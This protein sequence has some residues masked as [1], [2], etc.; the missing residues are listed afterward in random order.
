MKQG[1]NFING[2]W[3]DGENSL[4]TINPNNNQPFGTIVDSNF[5]EVS[6]AVDAA[7]TAFDLWKN[8]AMVERANILK[9]VVDYLVAA[10]GEPSE[11]TDL[12]QLISDEM[13]KR[14]PE[15][16]IEVIETSDML[17]YFVLNA[18]KYLTSFE[19]SLNQD[20]WATKSSQICF[21]PKGVVAII[22]AWNYPL[23]IPIWA[24][25]PALI[26]GNTVVFKPSEHSTFVAI[27]LVKMFEKAGLPKGVLNL[28]SGGKKTGEYLIDNKEISMVSFTGSSKTGTAINVKC[29]QNHIKCSLEL[30]G[31]DA[32]LVLKDADLE[33]TSNGLIW[34]AFCNSGQVCVGIKRA[35]IHS[36]VYENLTDLIIAKAKLLRPQIDFGPIVSDK[37]LQIVEHY[38]KDAVSKGAKV[39]FGGN[40]LNLEGFYYSPTILSNINNDML[41]MREECFGLILPLIQYDDNDEVIRQINNSKYGLGASIW[42]SNLENAKHI[43]K[44]IQSGMVWIND[45]NV[46]FPEAP[47]S[48]LKISGGGIDLSQFSL[49]E[50]VNLKHINTELS[51]EQRRIW[52]YPY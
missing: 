16:D 43:A 44:Q 28:I 4:T 13:G 30:S 21:E 27:E 3:V 6:D 17:N 11:I 5:K 31:N 1:K 20:L 52:W 32:T 47:W 12:K 25:A 29:A 39:L 38:V 34:G 37:Q 24:I 48:G 36:T 26:S 51:T 41:L 35:Y 14:I 2:E 50:Y 19:P 23:E 8:M 40:R 49:Y 18:E 9:K 7:K 15:A 22:K 33:L 10:Y 42:S 45:V 46:A